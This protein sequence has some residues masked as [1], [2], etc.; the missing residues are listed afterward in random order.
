MGLL[1][2]PWTPSILQDRYELPGKTLQMGERKSHSP[3]LEKEGL[4]IT[5]FIVSLFMESPTLQNWKIWANGKK[6]DPGEG[7]EVP[8]ESI[9]HQLNN[10]LIGD[11]RGKKDSSEFMCVCVCA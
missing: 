10:I 6:F 2:H 1:P 9:V 8:R 7:T 11:F 3:H 5:I 4:I